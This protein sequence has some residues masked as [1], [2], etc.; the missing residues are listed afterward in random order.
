MTD[1]RRDDPAARWIRE[2]WSPPGYRDDEPEF[3]VR[4]T[5]FT[6]ETN[7]YALPVSRELIDDPTRARYRTDILREAVDTAILR[8]E[9]EVYR[10]TLPSGSRTYDL[11]VT[12]PYDVTVS[13]DLPRPWWARL[14]RRPRRVVT[15]RV[16]GTVHAAAHVRVDLD[17]VYRCPEFRGAGPMVPTGSAEIRPGPVRVD[18]VDTYPWTGP[19]AAESRRGLRCPTRDGGCGHHIATHVPADDIEPGGCVVDGCGCRRTFDPR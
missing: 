18:T 16:G 8:V 10:A 1:E 6:P 9:R 2:A 13:V 11:D 14:L 12:V 4:Q 5:V 19:H 3:R 7:T 15:R 17:A